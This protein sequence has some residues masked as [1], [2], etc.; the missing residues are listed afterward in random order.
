MSWY[1]EYD[2]F[3]SQPLENDNKFLHFIDKGDKSIQITIN[4]NGQF[5][6]T[7]NEDNSRENQF[8]ANIFDSQQN[9]ENQ[10][11][12][13]IQNDIWVNKPVQESQSEDIL[14]QNYVSYEDKLTK[15]PIKE[16]LQEYYKEKE[17]KIKQQENENKELKNKQESQVNKLDKDQMEVE[18]QLNDI[19]FNK[20]QLFTD[21][22]IPNS[23]YQ[24]LS[25]DKQNREILTWLK[26]WDEIVFDH[27]KK[28]K[29]QI[30]P[31]FLNKNTNENNNNNFNNA[32]GKF[33][34]GF[35]KIF[36]LQNEQS[37]EWLQSNVLLLSGPPG[38]GKTTLS[39][40]IAEHCGYNPIEINASDERT[41]EKLIEKIESMGNIGSLTKDVSGKNKPTLIIFDEADGALEQDGFGAID[42]LIHY[43]QT[44]QKKLNKKQL[45][46]AKESTSNTDKKVNQ[47]GQQNKNNQS[48]SGSLSKKKIEFKNKK[49]I[50]NGENKENIGNN[51]DEDEATLLE[52]DDLDQ[53]KQKKNK[54]QRDDDGLRNLR[55][56]AITFQFQKVR[57]EKLIQRLKEICHKE[58]IYLDDKMLGQIARASDYDIRSSLNALEMVKKQ[59]LEGLTYEQILKNEQNSNKSVIQLLQ[60]IVYH[61]RKSNNDIQMIKNDL[62]YYTFNQL[63]RN[64]SS[65]QLLETLF[66]NYLKLD[67]KSQVKFNQIPEL[68]LPFLN[69]G[70]NFQI[71]ERPKFEFPLDAYKRWKRTRLTDDIIFSLL[72][73]Y[74]NQDKPYISNRK[75]ILEYA[76]NVNQIIQPKIE[77]DLTPEQTLSY[78]SRSVLQNNYQLVKDQK[79]MYNEYKEQGLENKLIFSM[80]NN[81]ELNKKK[82]KIYRDGQVT[83]RHQ[84]GLS[85]PI[86]YDLKMEYFFQ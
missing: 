67:P 22:Y 85:I 18:G 53:K 26:A 56:M 70:L 75:F 39:R 6:E 30:N 60:D 83:Y 2:N 86:K 51:E 35:F 13:N 25:E 66:L 47:N 10:N 77:N 46:A 14:M 72:E 57:P 44:G 40:V 4:T 31:I 5:P 48:G 7:N 65:E 62:T 73:N 82:K 37:V 74:P 68:L 34:Q 63:L 8:K 36:D 64:V 54:E 80:E 81:I 61:S 17:E 28:K 9:L 15:I 84:E 43:I 3:F 50:K 23:Y 29:Q 58:H 20:K 55:K 79:Q 1:N 76:S 71:N 41:P 33:G 52:G 78:K 19:S 69:T 38:C 21:K 27:K 11:N 42:A 59:R 24:L 49:K 12:L 32:Q 16:M 45:Q